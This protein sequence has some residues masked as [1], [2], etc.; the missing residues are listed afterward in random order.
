[1]HKIEFRVWTTPE[2]CGTVLIAEGSGELSQSLIFWITEPGHRRKAGGN[3]TDLL[4]TLQSKK[5]NVLVMDVRLP[6]EMGFEAIST[7]TGL[8]RRLP[9]MITADENKAEQESRIRDQGIFA[10]R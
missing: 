5:I 3:F 2:K 7:V 9:F 6:E 4:V 1:L 10:L 8:H